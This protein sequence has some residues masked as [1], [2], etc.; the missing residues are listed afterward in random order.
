MIINWDF[1]KEQTLWSY[2]DLIK[3]LYQAL[4]YEFVQEHYNHSMDEAI[5]YVDAVHA[6]YLQ[7]RSDRTWLDNLITNFAWLKRA[8][9]QNYLDLVQQVDS[10]EKCE[11]FLKRS[12][13]GFPELIETLNYLLRWVLPFPTPLRE[14]FDPDNATQMAYFQLL[15]QQR[16]TINLD[17]LEQGRTAAKRTH[18]AALTGIPSEFLLHLVHQADLSRLAYVRGKTVRHLCGGG[19][20]TLAK[21][22]NAD[23]QEMEA[24]M[25]VYYQTLGK[26]FADFKSVL[27]L[28]PL[29]GGARLLPK[30]VET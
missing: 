28:A 19:Y 7:H 14:F 29:V 16:I 2:E 27:P 4:N 8:G 25:S 20:D 1:V 11:A 26:R 6:G 12:G 17:L 24:A 3:K 5:D 18:L 22:A 15:K 13:M 30:I 10:R 21:L 9:V 23:L